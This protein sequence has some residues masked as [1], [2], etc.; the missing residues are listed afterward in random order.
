[1]VACLDGSRRLIPFSE[2]IRFCLLERVY[3]PKR[4]CPGQIRLALQVEWLDSWDTELRPREVDTADVAVLC[5]SQ[6]RAD[7]GVA[8]N[9]AKL[10]CFPYVY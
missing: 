9:F 6:V 1:V 8:D 4:V 10:I 7:E 2:N 3:L 5:D